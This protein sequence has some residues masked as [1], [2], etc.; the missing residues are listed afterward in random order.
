[1]ASP[2][3]LRV[4]MGSLSSPGSAIWRPGSHIKCFLHSRRLTSDS[5]LHFCI[6]SVQTA[7]DRRPDL[8]RPLPELI[9]FFS[10]PLLNQMGVGGRRYLSNIKVA[11]CFPL[12]PETYQHPSHSCY[13]LRNT[14]KHRYFQR[15][16]HP[17]NLKSCSGSSS[18]YPVSLLGISLLDHKELKLQTIKSPHLQLQACWALAVLARREGKKH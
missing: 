11:L 8:S 15:E 3:E 7:V 10:C 16:S 9:R 2:P 6:S 18:N 14:M 4:L 5:P 13:L 17:C 1:M 12:S